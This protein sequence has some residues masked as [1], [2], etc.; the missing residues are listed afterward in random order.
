VSIIRKNLTQQISKVLPDIVAELGKTISG[1]SEIGNEWAQLDAYHLMQKCITA[2][3]SRVLVG[4][5]LTNDQEFLESLLTL[6]GSVS[7]AG[8][9][10]DLAPRFL[11]PIIAF[12][13]VRQQTTQDISDETWTSLRRT[14]QEHSE[15]W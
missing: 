4:G 1:N 15:I 6:S 13:L 7:W 10:I 2:I 12:C 11:K 9:I 8:L 5:A 14:S 3:T